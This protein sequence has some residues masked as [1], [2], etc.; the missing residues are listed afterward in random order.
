MSRRAEVLTAVSSTIIVAAVLIATQPRDVFWGADNGNR[1]IQLQTFVRTH[2]IAIDTPGL[3]GIH[4]VRVGAKMYSIYSPVFS[5][6]CAPLYVLLGFP[7]LFVPSIVG[8]IALVCMMPALSKGSVILTAT[9][10]VFAT[11]LFWYTL[12]FW[13]HTLFVA[14]AVGAF[15]LAERGK[16]R[17]A[18]ML[19]GCATLL[20]EEGYVVIASIAV[21]CFVTRRPTREALRLAAAASAVL[22]P[23]WAVN[24]AV[25]GHPFGI[26]ALFYQLIAHGTK[27]ANVFPYLFEFSSRS[28]H[29]TLLMLPWVALIVSSSFRIAQWQRA[30]LFALVAAA[31]AGLTFLMLRSG[32]PIRETLYTQGLFTAVPFSATIFLNVPELWREQRFR[33][34]TVVCGIVLTTVVVTQDFGVIWGPRYYL[35]IV[36]LM[37]V[38]GCDALGTF[39]LDDGLPQMIVVI[40]AAAFLV[41]S[42]CIQFT[43]VR[44]LRLK[45]S[46]SER[47]LSTV[48][49]DPTKIVVTD[50]FWI[51]EELA[52]I[53]SEKR[54]VLVLNDAEFIRGMTTSSSPFLFVASNSTRRISNEA[55]RPMLRRVSRRRRITVADLD[56][57]LLNVD[58]PR[59][60]G[61]RNGAAGVH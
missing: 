7:G 24:F 3:R 13:E 46:F 42:F 27:V 15:M 57:I 10:L 4:F 9:V 19:A 32:Q 23:W 56:V 58:S 37:I 33:L 31:S 34:V 50:V 52:A 39:L 48:S 60:N 40:S 25:F 59:R 29:A 6:L 1:F 53:L 20:R 26:H 41:V 45:L 61:T 12:V 14:L 17:L 49:K 11:P 28:P 16:P 44:I 22:L 18:G 30:A 21:A 51:P 43:G 54:M 55:I 47:L 36:P 35:W 38:L 8:T 5:I 2:G